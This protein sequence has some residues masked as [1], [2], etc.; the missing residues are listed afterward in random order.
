[1]V[2]N[3]TVL[4]DPPAAP[5]SERP[6][7]NG[8]GAGEVSAPG[9]SPSAP[10]PA[11]GSARACAN[12]GAALVEGQDWCLQCGVAAPGSLETG[13]P[14]WRSATI[15]LAATAA[16]VLGAGAAAYAALTQPSSHKVVP[17]VI[18]IAQVPTTPTGAVTA[19]TTATSSGATA[20]PN[21][22][23]TPTTIKP[24]GGT[25]TPPKIPLT[26][27][28]PK[29][30]PTTSTPGTT[31]KSGT[32]SGESTKG[33]TK[34]TTGSGGTTSTEQPT[35]ILLDTNA[36]STYN[37]YNYPAS[38]FG[39]PS[40]AIDGETS[41]A[42]TAQVEP[43]VAPRM[44]V[45]LAIDLKTPQRVGSITLITSTPGMTVQVYGA[46][47]SALPTSITDPAWV[48]LSPSLDAKKRKTR[49][50]LRVPSSDRTTK[51]FRFI[52]LWISAAPQSSVGTPSAPGH[53][54]VN[55]LELFPP[56]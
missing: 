3:P 32:G 36:A 35:P 54:S 38:S 16:L 6:S 24:L 23:G 28:T 18:T 29:S 41:T 10:G 53:V 37:P 2:V 40:L 52:T 11:L 14:G 20:T 7:T 42:W 55:E 51:E 49:I 13:G 19:P 39:D 9:A 5:E 30:S 12:C 26:A 17:K 48:T 27:P 45:G 50:T 31:T 47:G 8:S 1:M 21:G 34:S 25:T 56:K 33:T 44:A 22:L 43:S 4:A 15:V 46:N